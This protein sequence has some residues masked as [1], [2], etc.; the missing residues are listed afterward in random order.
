MDG[1]SREYLLMCG[2]CLYAQAKPADEPAKKAKAI[3]EV[4]AE[5]TAAP[6]PAPAAE[7]KAAAPEEPAPAKAD[8]PKSAVVA[9]EPDLAAA[10]AAAIVTPATGKPASESAASNG[11]A[12]GG[13][14]SLGV[15]SPSHRTSHS[16]VDVHHMTYVRANYAQMTGGSMATALYILTESK[17]G[18]LLS[19]APHIMVSG[20]DLYNHRPA[21]IITVPAVER[22]IKNRHANCI[23]RQLRQV[24]R[25]RWVKSDICV[26]QE[27]AV[28]PILKRL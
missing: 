1:S 2:C 25:L 21:R 24:I 18:S 12:A 23:C 11:A 10:L 20:D 28:R 19:S 7:K 4:A 3:P 6:V 14:N 17:S 15:P 27:L 8:E 26:R 22:S 13:A 5:P 16:G 9:P